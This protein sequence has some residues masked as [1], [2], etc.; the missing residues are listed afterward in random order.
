MEKQA[1]S[2]KT[3]EASRKIGWTMG[4]YGFAVAAVVL[5][6]LS[7]STLTAWIGPGLPPYITFYPVVMAVALFAD[8]WPAVLATILSG[9]IAGFWVLPPVGELSSMGPVD[10]VGLVLFTGMGLFMS[11]AFRLY[12]RH[13]D[14]AAAYDSELAL[15]E[16][17]ER[18]RLAQ[19]A[20]NVG[21]WDWTLDTGQ[22]DWTPEL[23][24]LFGY[25]PGTFPGNYAGFSDRVHP[26]DISEIERQREAAVAAHLPFDF[27]F[28]VCLPSG[29][30][31]W[32][33]CKG[34]ARYDAAGQPQRVFGVNLDI[35]DRK[36]AEEALRTSEKQHAAILQTAMDGFMLLDSQGRLLQV[37]DTYC[38]MSGYSEPELLLKGISDLDAAESLDETKA[39][40]RKIMDLGE[41]RFESRH[42]RKDGTVFDVEVSVQYKPDNGGYQVVFLRDISE[43]KRSSSALVE[44]E[45]R[46]STLIENLPGVAYRCKVDGDW[47]MLFI[48]EGVLKLAGYRPEDLLENRKLAYADLIHS[49]D[50][51]YVLRAIEKAVTE[52][53]HFVLEYRIITSTGEEKWVWERG[54]GILDASGKIGILEGFVT[55]IS[56][57]KKAEMELVASQKLIKAI[58]NAIPARVFWKDRNLNFLGCNLSFA[59]DAGFDDPKLIIGKSDYQM[60]WHDQADLYRNDDRQVIESGIGKFLIE[61]PQTTPSGDVITLLTSKMPLRNATGEIIGV[62]GTYLDI[63]ERK[64][65]EEEIRESEE[66]NRSLIDASA[67]AILVRSMGMITHANPAALKLFR[68]KTEQDLIGKRYLDLVHPDDRAESAERVRRNIEESWIA[69]PR[70]HRMLALDG[71]VVEVESTGVPVRFRGGTQTFGIFRD[72]TERK[73]AYQEKEKL[74]DQ[75]RQAQK[76]E[77]LGTLAG[78]IAHDFNNILGVIIGSSEILAMTDAVEQDAKATLNNILSA[79]QRAKDLVRQI[80][81]FSRHAKQEKI[82][83]NLKPLVRETF[84]FLRASIPASIQLKNRFDPDTGAIMADPTQMQQVLMNLCTNAAHAMEADGGVLKVELSKI[85]LGPEDVQFDPDLEPGKYVR[86][87]VSDTGHG[88]APEIIDKV[89]DPYFTTKKKGKGTGLGL[90]VVHGI[91]KAHGGAIKV[92]SEVGKGTTFQVFLPG[93]QGQEIS[94]VRAA[95]ALPGGKERILLVDDEKALADIEKQM[96]SWLG[97]EVEVRTS[98]VEALEAFRANPHRFDLVITDFSMPQMTGTKL[99]RQMAQIRPGVPVI[100]CTGFSEQLD[101]HQMAPSGIKSI[102]LKPLVATELAAEVR[103]ALEP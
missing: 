62:L 44:S 58:I 4:R 42:R 52:S 98:A 72:I 20:A 100:L 81:A 59:H 38:R 18:L 27:D 16:S 46:L 39:H 99:A 66:R 1:T 19:R 102:L 45:R 25:A 70:E 23:A 6:Y 30:T 43:Q 90:S 82:L 83:L 10:R 51:E 34:A 37:N 61:E 84:D 93:A 13:R 69:P 67:D 86:M 2:F 21:I 8:F 5:G 68:A 47:T 73:K 71:Q 31:R 11:V 97:Y 95:P 26:D 101:E 12:R 78:G 22:L 64:R 85:A 54:R 55:D 94:E 53:L 77:S 14:K 57:R 60:G 29:E 9:I 88:I 74:E 63:T 33:N 50:R 24:L 41:D 65:V 3:A 80:L 75:L 49:E 79:S 103:K 7:W 91:V 17:Q 36:Q 40:I 56:E 76:M 28:R 32:V 96:L 87:T 15:R 48:S 89:F 92:Y 35:T